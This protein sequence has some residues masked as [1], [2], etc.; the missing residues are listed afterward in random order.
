M[1]LH[2]YRTLA[3]YLPSLLSRYSTQLLVISI[4]WL[5]QGQ[6][7]GLAEISAALLPFYAGSLAFSVLASVVDCSTGAV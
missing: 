6:G 2:P 7:I 4:P 1:L 3:V 5:L